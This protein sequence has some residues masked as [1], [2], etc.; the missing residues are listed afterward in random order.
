MS[1]LLTRPE[2]VTEPETDEPEEAHYFRS[3]DVLRSTI[4]GVPVQALCGLWRVVTRAPDNLPV[5]P[6]CEQA[7][8][9]IQSA[10]RGL[11]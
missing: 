7:M 6:R 10:D 11:N 8:A 2:T 5:C 3:E 9:Q 1:D 4:E